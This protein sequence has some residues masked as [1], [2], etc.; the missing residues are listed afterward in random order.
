MH[1]TRA[2]IKTSLLGILLN[3]ILAGFKAFVGTASG[4]ISIFSD[5]INNL[6]DS[7]SSIVTIC[8]V[9]LARKKPDKGHPHGHGHFE[10]VSAVVISIIIFATGLS[11]LYESIQ[12]IINPEVATF[13]LPML[14]IILAGIVV[15]IFISKHFINRGKTLKSSS[16][17]ASGKDAFFDV[18]ISSGTLIGALITYFSGIT[19]DGWISLLISAVVIKSAIEIALENY[20]KIKQRK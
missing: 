17:V 13:S 14:A 3:L 19:I 11:L 20:P 16:L 12:K 2:V 6:S 1:R 9:I 8:G 5:A 10:P 15:K 7:V 18:L 4:S